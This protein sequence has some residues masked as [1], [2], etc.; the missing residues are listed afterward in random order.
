MSIDWDIFKELFEL[1]KF[2]CDFTTWIE[3]RA[4]TELYQTLWKVLLIFYKLVEEY[5]KHLA[6]YTTLAVSN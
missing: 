4:K 5:K 6:H 3:G 1:I 2:F